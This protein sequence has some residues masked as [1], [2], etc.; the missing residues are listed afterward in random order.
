[1]VSRRMVES[2]IVEMLS[3]SGAQDYT[4]ILGFVKDRFDDVTEEQLSKALMI[5]EIHGVL[6]VYSASKD[7]QRVELVRR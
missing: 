2:T 4:S 3:K 7:K 6:R 1:M 5:L